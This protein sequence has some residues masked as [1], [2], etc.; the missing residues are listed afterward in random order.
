M[1]NLKNSLCFKNW[2]L[3][4]KKMKLQTSISPELKWFSSS[5]WLW[6][7]ETLVYRILTFVTKHH[8][9]NIVCSPP[10]PLSWEISHFFYGIF[11]LFKCTFKIL[12]KYLLLFGNNVNYCEYYLYELWISQWCLIMSEISISVFSV[13]FDDMKS[14]KVCITVC[15]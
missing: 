6:W 5:F 4:K 8:S 2:Q 7:K 1:N 13:L 9:V 15:K 14:G 3:K 10:P 12:K 11:C